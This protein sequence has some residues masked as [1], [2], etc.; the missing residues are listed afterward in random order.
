[1]LHL[2]AELLEKLLAADTG[3]RGPGIDCG[4]RHHGQ[5]HHAEFVSHP[6][7]SALTP[8]S[9]ATLRRAYYLCPAATTALLV[10]TGSRRATP[11]SA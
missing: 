10:A 1:M 7:Q 11:S 8:C 6:S 2:G 3:H 9:A 4:Q 5:G